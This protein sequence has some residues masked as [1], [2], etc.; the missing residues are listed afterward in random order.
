MKINLLGKTAIYRESGE[1]SLVEITKQQDEDWGVI[2]TL[3][4]N[5]NKFAR[6]N[7]DDELEYYSKEKF[8]SEFTISGAW[9]VVFLADDILRIAYVGVSLNFSKRAIEAFIRNEKDVYELW[10]K[11]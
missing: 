10:N 4:I 8:N 6:E 11:K 3:N 2:L 5:D 7:D 9:D 1:F